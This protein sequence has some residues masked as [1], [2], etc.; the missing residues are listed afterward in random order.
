MVAEVVDLNGKARK[1]K[2]K[3]LIRR[4]QIIDAARAILIREGV[5]GLVLRDIADQLKIT[6]GNLQYYFPTKNDLLKAVFQDQASKYINLDR[7]IK[8]RT[9]NIQDRIYAIVDTAIKELE[10]ES[11]SLWFMLMS[12]SSQNKE[13]ADILAKA[14]HYYEKI[15]NEELREIVPEMPEKKRTNIAKLISMLLDGLSIKMIYEDPKGLDISTL[16][17]EIK[18][19]IVSMIDDNSSLKTSGSWVLKVS[20]HPVDDPLK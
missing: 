17:D 18:A 3:S 19:S 14:N 6:H 13:L 4:Q 15:L 20:V 2:K 12:L 7:E 5:N 10:N 1:F 9:S 11:T 8:N 16:K